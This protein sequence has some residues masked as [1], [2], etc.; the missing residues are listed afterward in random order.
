MSWLVIACLKNAVLALPIAAAALAVGRMSRRPA[1]AHV[2]WVLVLVKLITPPLVD[3]PVGWSI[4]LEGWLTNVSVEDRTSPH[5]TA[6]GLAPAGS[7]LDQELDSDNRGDALGT[8]TGPASGW[9]A[10]QYFRQF[11]RGIAGWLRSS[12]LKFLM[13]VTA[14][15]WLVGSAVTAAV[16]Y[17]RAARF[18]RYLRLAIRDDERLTIRVRQLSYRA[19]LASYPRVVVVDGVVSPMLW[20]VGRGVRLLF[21]AR[22]AERLAAAET[23]ALLLHELAHYA[24]GDHWIRLLELTAYVAH[25]WNPIVWLACRQI[26]SAEEQCCDAWVVEHQSGTRLTYAEALLATID[27]LNEPAE[28]RPPAACGL[29]D[30]PLLRRRLKQIMRGELAGQLPRAAWTMVLLVGLALAPLEPAIFATSARP[31]SGPVAKVNEQLPVQPVEP[32]SPG[33]L[34]D[35]FS[36]QSKDAPQPA[37]VPA[38]AVPFTLPALPEV[39][40]PS[41]LYASVVSPNNQYKLEA[42][43]G[44]R[45]FLSKIGSGLGIDLASQEFTCVS[46]SPLPD[47]RTFV[48]GH[49]DGKIRQWDS[50][51]GV[52]MATIPAA[53]GAIASIAYSPDGLQF[54]SATI[55]GLITVWNAAE[56]QEVARI[57]HSRGAVSCLRWSPAGDRLAITLGDWS[58]RSQSRLQ[59]WVPGDSVPLSDDTLSQPAGAL[60]WL[61]ADVVLVAA[62][63]GSAIVRNLRGNQ[64]D[65]AHQVGKQEVSAANWSSDVRMVPK[66]VADRLV[67]GAGL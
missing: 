31:A 52:W 47:C 54:A 17:L 27:F 6:P 62:W 29:G 50:E 4:D 38:E 16:L 44:R 56:H 53:G 32:Q 34:A 40:Q 3:V 59:V 10:S 2:L 37:Q 24:R 22:L 45:T 35:L 19:G 60:E 20:G 42:R 7:R 8:A 51:T 30:V 36:S 61:A 49:K 67:A 11:G 1:L 25:W 48:S 39:I 63:D 21:P 26:E 33:N 43:T 12:T 9:S 5:V 23:D 41:R 55:D 64:P 14:V 13:L 46:F 28:I 18:S 65:L 57:V 15:L 66:F 58:Q